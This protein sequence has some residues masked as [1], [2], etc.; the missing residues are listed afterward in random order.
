MVLRCYWKIKSNSKFYAIIS[1][2][3]KL[4]IAQLLKLEAKTQFVG[5]EK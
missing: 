2:L 3:H 1:E 4:G 5:V